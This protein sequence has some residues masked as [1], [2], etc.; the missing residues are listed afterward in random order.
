MATAINK[1]G[2]FGLY[3]YATRTNVPF[4]DLT[5]RLELISNNETCLKI[6]HLRFPYF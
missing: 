5:P 4:F 3:R 1:T 2:D 6:A